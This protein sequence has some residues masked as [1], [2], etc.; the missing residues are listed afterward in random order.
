M[1]WSEKW[2][3]SCYKLAQRFANG[4]I[5]DPRKEL[6]LA[7]IEIEE[8]SRTLDSVI[9]LVELDSSSIDEAYHSL[10]A[11]DSGRTQT[12]SAIAGYQFNNKSYIVQMSARKVQGEIQSRTGKSAVLGRKAF[13]LINNHRI[14]IILPEI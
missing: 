4:S 7:L 6:N 9:A 12:I 1:R 11:Q 8:D 14:K 2:F 3:R 5:L 13:E 10:K